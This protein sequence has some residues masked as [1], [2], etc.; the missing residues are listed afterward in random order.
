MNHMIHSIETPAIMN[1]VIKLEDFSALIYT[2]LETVRALKSYN[3]LLKTTL[4]RI[5]PTQKVRK[6]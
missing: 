6:V 2:I 1:H 5:K 4:G 3:L